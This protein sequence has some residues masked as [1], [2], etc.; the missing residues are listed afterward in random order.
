MPV[1]V[2]KAKTD[3]IDQAAPFRRSLCMIAPYHKDD[4]E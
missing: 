3:I 1:N 2:A 4:E